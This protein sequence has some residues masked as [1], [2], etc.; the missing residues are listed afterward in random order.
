MYTIIGLLLATLALLLCNKFI[1]ISHAL[2]LIRLRGPLESNICSELSDL[3][4]VVPLDIHSSVFDHLQDIQ[5]FIAHT[6]ECRGVS[7]STAVATARTTNG[8]L[9]HTCRARQA[10]CTAW[11]LHSSMGTNPRTFPSEV[12]ARKTASIKLPQ[13]SRRQ[14]RVSQSRELN[15]CKKLGQNHLHSS[16]ILQQG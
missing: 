12:I 14:S 15:K 2:S 6:S 3:N 8:H 4:L 5:I 16:K 9:L 13:T 10:S 1:Y 7:T 11:S